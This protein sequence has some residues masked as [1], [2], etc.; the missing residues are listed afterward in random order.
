[1]K[2]KLYTEQQILGGSGGGS[3]GNMSESTASR[4][5]ILFAGSLDSAGRGCQMGS[6]FAGLNPGSRAL[7]SHGGGQN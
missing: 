7:R 5:K 4:S 6:E 2:C 1:M 3:V